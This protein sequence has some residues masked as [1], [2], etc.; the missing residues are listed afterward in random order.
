MHQASSTRPSE[1]AFRST[2]HAPRSTLH[3]PQSPAGFT[4]LELLAVFIIIAVLAGTILGITKYAATNA[5]TSRARAEIATMET[6]LE[7][8]KNDNGTY[9]I[10]LAPR[11]TDA[12][13]P[14]Y[15]N[16]PTLYTAL[17]GGPGNPKTYFHFKPN[18]I[19]PIDLTTTNIIDPFGVPYNYY[20]TLP[21]QLDQENKAT[22]DLWSYGPDNKDDGPNNVVNDIV[23]WRR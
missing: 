17:A 22:F 9:P 3:A 11:P 14:T 2:L 6:A 12:N 21:V 10:T 16:S 20:C 8:Y 15:G 5:A 1:V 23:N 19:Q 18:Q 7:G 4:L 13:A